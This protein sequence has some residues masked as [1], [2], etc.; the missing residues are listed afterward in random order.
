MA[1]WRAEQLEQE[2]AALR[3][4]VA[5]LRSERIPEPAERAAR[6]SGSKR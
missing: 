2:L 6:K 1:D 4:E 3:Q 5:A